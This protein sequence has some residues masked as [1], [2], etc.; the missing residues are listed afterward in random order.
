M[1]NITK[2]KMHIIKEL[3]KILKD[4]IYINYKKQIINKIFNKNINS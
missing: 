1:Q 3:I 2:N 4:I